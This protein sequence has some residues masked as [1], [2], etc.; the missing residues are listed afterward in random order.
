ME[1][2][3]YIRQ[4]VKQGKNVAVFS[5][6]DPYNTPFHHDLLGVN[7]HYVHFVPAA[8]SMISPASIDLGLQAKHIDAFGVFGHYGVIHGNEVCA[9]VKA[10]AGDYSHYGPDLQK[11]IQRIAEKFAYKVDKGL[12]DNVLAWTEKQ[13]QELKELIKYKQR[14][15]KGAV[16]GPI[17]VFAGIVQNLEEG[18]KYSAEVIWHETIDQKLI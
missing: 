15:L 13:F 12:K 3:P 10:L 17:E 1:A 9:A 6:E 2:I 11:A 14:T 16:K 8:G 5:C 7:P 18:K 4:L